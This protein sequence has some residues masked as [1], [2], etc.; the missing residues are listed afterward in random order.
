MARRPQSLKELARIANVGGDIKLGQW[1]DDMRRQA[2]AALAATTD[3]AKALSSGDYKGEK[4][5]EGLKFASSFFGPIGKGVGAG[6]SL[7]DMLA[8]AKKAKKK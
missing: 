2:E 8:D 6:L 1:Y 4:I 5:L 3:K 7:I